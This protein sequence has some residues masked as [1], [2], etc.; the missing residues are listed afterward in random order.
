MLPTEVRVGWIFRYAYLWEWQYR[1]GREEG[2]KDRPCLVLAIVGTDADGESVVRVLPI[3]HTPPANPGDAIEIPIVVAPASGR[4]ALL[5]CAH[6]EQP[7]HLA[8][9]RFAW[10]RSRPWV[11]WP[12]AAQF[13]RRG[14]TPLCGD[15]AWRNP[16]K[17]AASKR[18][19]Q[20]LTAARCFRPPLA[21]RGGG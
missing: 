20:H 11:L 9:S 5:D 10:R 14:K 7:L 18:A 12:S 13:I 19:T 6:R 2:D 17:S 8:G 1:A 15:R 21:W 3:T 4:R 16:G